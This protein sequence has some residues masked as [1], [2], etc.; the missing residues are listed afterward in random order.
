M[1][2]MLRFCARRTSSLARICSSQR[3]NVSDVPQ[4]YPSK[5]RAF[6]FALSEEEA[7][8]RMSLPM[9]FKCWLRNIWGSFGATFLP[10]MGFKPL[11]PDRIQAVYI[12]IWFVDAEVE[13][14]AWLSQT[15]SQEGEATQRKVMAFFEQSFV[16]GFAHEPLSRISLLNSPELANTATIRYTDDLRTQ[17]GSEILCMP[18]F[19]TPFSLLNLASSLSYRQATVSGNMRLNPSTVKANLLAAYPVLIPIYL[20]QYEVI[21]DGQKSIRF[22]AI[23]EA[24]RKQGRII[25][26]D[27]DKDA[28]QLPIR[29]DPNASRFLMS[30]T[31][32]L[33]PGEFWTYPSSLDDITS[34]SFATVQLFTPHYN[35]AEQVTLKNWINGAAEREGAI[36]EYQ[37]KFFSSGDQPAVDW[38]DLRIREYKPTETFVNRQWMNLGKQL[39]LMRGVLSSILPFMQAVAGSDASKRDDGAQTGTEDGL[40]ASAPDKSSPES[41]SVPKEFEFEIPRKF[42]KVTEVN[43]K[44]LEKMRE[45]SKP[46]WLREWE[47]RT[48]GEESER[49]NKET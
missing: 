28:A 39:V 23:L 8:V 22:T 3:R 11:Q 42:P 49:V 30:L 24:W 7:I 35:K 40:S 26:E 25:A 20:A 13:A 46:E 31:E 48:A 14:H 9:S 21:S 6:P 43:P 41:T 2:I 33:S 29:N 5:V 44:Q 4:T 1:S 34:G 17:R 12:P 38:E 36:E 19:I 16:P 27:V 32:L 45:E 15:S 47:R 37:T 18:Y 10:G